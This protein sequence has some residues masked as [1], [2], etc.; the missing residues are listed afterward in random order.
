MMSAGRAAAGR[1]TAG[2]S[3]AGASAAG[4]RDG[5]G[6]HRITA[7]RTFFMLCT[8]GGSCCRGIY[9]PLSCG[10][11]RFRAFD[12][13]ATT[14]NCTFMPV[15]SIIR[16]PFCACG[17]SG[18]RNLHTG[19]IGN[20]YRSCCICEPLVTAIAGVVCGIARSSAGGS[21]RSNQSQIVSVRYS[22]VISAGV[23]NIVRTVIVSRFVLFVV[24][25]R[26][27]VPVVCRIVFPI[28]T[29]CMT[30]SS[31]HRYEGI[32]CADCTAG[33]AL[34]IYCVACAVSR[35]FKC[36]RFYS[37][38]II[39]MR[40]WS[41]LIGRFHTYCTCRHCKCCGCTVCVCKGNAAAYNFPLIKYLAGRSRICSQSNGCTF[42]RF[43]D[44]ASCANCRFT[45]CNGDVV[46]YCSR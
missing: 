19:F 15:V 28:R 10:M 43:A 41:V 29:I 33:A 14:C 8:G 27:F 36:F 44:F 2:G 7:D 32:C 39:G 1:T 23:A 37:F 31:I 9:N 40:M 45:V 22:F 34:E 11:S 42:C 38:L 12:N 4:C 16:L 17:M 5:F 6:C 18:S 35:G 26:T 13:H 3:T 25:T 46:L 30:E 20:F 21:F 24:A